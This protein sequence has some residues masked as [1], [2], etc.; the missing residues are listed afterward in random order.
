MAELVVIG[1]V[2]GLGLMIAVAFLIFNIVWRQN[3]SEPCPVMHAE[4]EIH[5]HS[6]IK[7]FCTDRFVKASSPWINVILIM[8]II[9]RMPVSLLSSLAVST[10][11]YGFNSSYIVP[12]C[13]VSLKNSAILLSHL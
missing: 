6:I 5:N 3:K 4:L 7:Y 9:I 11:K 8:G 2:V 1:V 12:L 10:A 13:Y